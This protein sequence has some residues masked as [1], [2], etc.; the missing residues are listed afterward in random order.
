MPCQRSPSGRRPVDREGMRNCRPLH[1]RRHCARTTGRSCWRRARLRRRRQCRLASGSPALAGLGSG[2]CRSCLHRSGIARGRCNRGRIPRFP[3]RRH[4]RHWR[5]RTPRSSSR[6]PP[7]NA[8]AQACI[9]A[10]S[11]QPPATGPQQRRSP[12][13]ARVLSTLFAVTGQTCGRSHRIANRPWAPRFHEPVAGRSVEW[14]EPRA[15]RRLGTRRSTT[16]C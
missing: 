7:R 10:P 2:N 4:R 9:A 14:R 1:R 11:R 5:Y 3:G 6:S 16:N 8:D 13:R 12:L 15:S